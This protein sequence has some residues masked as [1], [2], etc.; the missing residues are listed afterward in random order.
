MGRYLDYYKEERQRYAEVPDRKMT[1]D[2]ATIALRKLCKHFKVPGVSL[3]FTSGS[4][5]SHFSPG[6]HHIRLNLDDP[7]GWMVLAH[8]MAHYLHHELKKKQIAKIHAQSRAAKTGLMSGTEV[9]EAVLAWNKRIRR[10]EAQRWHG[11]HHA[12]IQDRVFVY[13][14]KQGWNEGSLS[15]QLQAREEAATEREQKVKAAKNSSEYKIAMRQAQIQRLERK[16]KALTTRLKKAK[17]SLGALERAKAKKVSSVST[18]EAQEKA[19]QTCKAL[20]EAFSHLLKDTDYEKVGTEKV[21]ELL[22]F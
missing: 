16:I 20:D 13:I 18:A 11:R 4:R 5:R 17:R 22:T 9:A 1:P 7:Q 2:E 12:R 8:E 6:R 21:Q 3:Q 10:I 19:P 15:G 14:Q